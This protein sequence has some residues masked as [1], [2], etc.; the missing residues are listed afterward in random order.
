MQRINNSWHFDSTA[1]M[2]DAYMKL[3]PEIV[4]N[5]FRRERDTGFYGA[6]G[7]LDKLIGRIKH[8][9]AGFAERSRKLLEEFDHE[10]PSCRSALDYAPAGF[11]PCVPEYIGGSPECM[12][13]ASEV[14]DNS[15]PLRIVVNLA[16]SQSI[17]S[18]DIERRGAVL[19][20]AVL[21][22]SVSR[23]VSLEIMIAARPYKQKEASAIVT[24]EGRQSVVEG[25][26]I[27][28]R[29]NSA[30]LDTASAGVALC[31]PAFCRL[32]G[33]GV[34][35]TLI[36]GDY[37][38]IL[39]PSVD[40]HNVVFGLPS[41]QRSV[42]VLLAMAGI[43]TAD[44]LYIPPIHAH[45]PIVEDTEAWMHDVLSRYAPSSDF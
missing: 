8:G 13:T 22:L 16:S 1:E 6:Y 34:S 26:V 18:K 43:D 41:E 38:N 28:A 23:P 30:P 36:R 2:C 7:S 19:L 4:T 20:A 15:A 39:W 9:D 33:Y 11:A 10:I 44:T 25:V 45:D 21:A 35:S 27:T 40:G 32:I 42:R 31:D 37:E 14:R 12:F 17:D 24:V 5:K 3:V 29:I